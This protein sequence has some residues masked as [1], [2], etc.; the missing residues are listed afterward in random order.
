M[1]YFTGDMPGVALILQ[2]TYK[3]ESSETPEKVREHLPNAVEYNTQQTLATIN[4]LPLD[5]LFEKLLTAT[6][7]Q[8]MDP[9]DIVHK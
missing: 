4:S 9:G 5:V 2:S 7:K 8:G 1:S 6:K 3:V